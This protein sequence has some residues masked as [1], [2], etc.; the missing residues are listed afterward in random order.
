M[1]YY[2]R[3]RN[4]ELDNKNFKNKV[5][6]KELKEINKEY[7]VN[8]FYHKRDNGTFVVSD[9]SSGLSITTANKLKTVKIFAISILDRFNGNAKKVLDKHS[10]DIA[11]KYGKLEDLPD[12]DIINVD[13]LIKASL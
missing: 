7:G 8:L 10:K 4:T 1:E 9:V 2:T 12:F 3:I 13:Y 5:N 6:G 11:I